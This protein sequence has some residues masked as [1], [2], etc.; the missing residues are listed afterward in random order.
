MLHPP[1]QIATTPRVSNTADSKDHWLMLLMIT[2]WNILQKAAGGSFWIHCHSAEPSQAW[3][4]FGGRLLGVGCSTKAKDKETRFYGFA[5]QNCKLLRIISLHSAVI[6]RQ[7]C[8][9][10]LPFCFCLFS[11]TSYRNSTELPWVVRP[12][13]TAWF[14]DYKN[15]RKWFPVVYVS[16]PAGADLD[17]YLDSYI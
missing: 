7:Y 11:L 12:F 10:I 1:K 4:R 14:E 9:K 6:K 15:Q 16:P 17:K 5:L 8:S 13:K 3:E 2:D